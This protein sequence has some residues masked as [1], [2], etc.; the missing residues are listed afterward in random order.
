MTIDK[1]ICIGKNYKEHALELGD[2]VSEKP[3]IFLKPPSILKQIN[4]WDEI[5]NATLPINHGDIHY[6]CEIVLQLANDGYQ[7]DLAQ[8]EQTIHAVT[9]GL[10]MTLRN[11]QTTLKKN[12]HP[13]TVAKVFPDAAIIGPWIPHHDF[14]NYLDNEFSLIINNQLR[15]HALGTQMIMKPAELLVYVSEYFPLCKGDIIFT[16]TPAGVG[17]ISSGDIAKLCWKD[18]CFE[19]K[20]K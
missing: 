7:M 19:V 16:G 3:V 14:I 12:G 18:K 9:L 4:Q 13:W 11:L 17:A 2:S 10:D 20:W 6:E 5:I 1:I 8:A 15:Q